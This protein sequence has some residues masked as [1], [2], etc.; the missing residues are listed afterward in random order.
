MKKILG[1]LGRGCV[2]MKVVLLLQHQTGYFHTADVYCLYN[3]S[4]N[5][6]LF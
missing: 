2:L 3:P 5:F 4:S 1:K 6:R